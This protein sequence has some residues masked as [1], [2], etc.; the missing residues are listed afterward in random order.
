[1]ATKL[2][3]GKKILLAEDDLALARSLMLKLEHEGYVVTAVHDGQAALTAFAKGGFQLII[4]DL[5]MPVLDGWGVLE[6]LK[7]G[8]NT[9]PVFVAS[10][11]GQQTDIDKARALGAKDFFVKS[12][13]SLAE[14]VRRIQTVI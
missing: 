5:I 1:M 9:V 2:T 6:K 12:D 14:I 7:E 10:N 8:G 13:T 4:V 11:L 3:K